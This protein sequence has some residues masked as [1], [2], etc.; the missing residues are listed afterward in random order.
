L[1]EFCFLAYVFI[2]IIFAYA[3]IK[4]HNLLGKSPA[5][6]LMEKKRLMEQA[7]RILRGATCPFCGSKTYVEQVD[8]MKE[9]LAVTTCEKCG[10]KCLWKLEGYTWHLIAPHRPAV[11]LPTKLEPP[12][13]I[14]AENLMEEIR[15]A[16]N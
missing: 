13:E 7:M 12:P 15:N 6:Q 1:F 5:E 2:V 16:I 4:H 9:N 8:M 10:Q 14:E 3:T 11:K